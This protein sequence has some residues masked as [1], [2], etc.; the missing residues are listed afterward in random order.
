MLLL[1]LFYLYSF[2]IEGEN[3]KIG[4][5]VVQ[6]LADELLNDDKVKKLPTETLILLAKRCFAEVTDRLQNS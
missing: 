3:E 1:I 2:F 5:E 6:S 4:S